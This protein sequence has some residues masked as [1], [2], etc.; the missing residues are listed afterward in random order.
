MFSKCRKDLFLASLL[1]GMILACGGVSDEQAKS[2]DSVDQAS[3]LP[4]GHPSTSPQVPAG[5]SKAGLTWDKP[6]GWVEETPSSSMRRAQYR[7]PAESGDGECVVFYFGPGQGGGAQA[8]AD[9]WAGQFEQP[10]GRPSTEVMETRTVTVERYVDSVHRGHRYLSLRIHDGRPD[11][12]EARSHASRSH[13]GGSGRQ[14]VLQIHRSRGHRAGESRSFRVDAPHSPFPLVD[15]A[16]PASDSFRTKS[17]D[18][19]CEADLSPECHF[20]KV[21]L[22]YKYLDISKDFWP[23]GESR[24]IHDEN[25][26]CSCALRHDFAC[27]M[28]RWN[29]PDNA[30]N[31]D[32]YLHNH[33]DGP[34]VS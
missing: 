3:E 22:Q 32:N 15:D 21:G 10:D 5:A 19:A 25:M 13:C 16:G 34:S 9:R 14:L 30:A 33:H 17:R 4:P 6:E 24:R 20:R 31:D 18:A 23:C 29:E 7:V 11:D 8:N 2:K 1:A 26:V 12:N 28:Q 27:W